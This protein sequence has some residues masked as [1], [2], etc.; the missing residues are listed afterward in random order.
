[1]RVIFNTDQYYLHGGIEKVMATKANYL[2][3]LPNF[4]VYILTTEQKGNS[5]C[6]PLDERIQ[7]IDLS[8]NYDRK[9]SYF[10]VANLSKI[11][12]HFL[13]QRKILKAIAP[14]III[15]PNYNFDH[16]WL[17]FLKSKKTSLI[18]EIHASGYLNPNQR[19]TANFINKL[20][21]QLNDYIL[22]KFSAVVV[23]NEDEK[24]YQ[25]NHNTIVIPNP[26]LKQKEKAVLTNKKVMTAGR[27]A[28]VKGFNHLVEAW[29]LVNLKHPEWVLHIYGDEYAD[30]KQR[31]EQ[32]ITAHK[33][34]EVIVFKD[35]VSNLSEVML[36][37]SVYAMSSVTECFPMVL[38]EAMSVG[39]P[40]VSYDCPNGPRH[41]VSHN[42]D[43]LLVENQN[44]NALANGIL[45]LIDNENMREKMGS[46]AK[47]NSAK[48]ATVFVMKKW[49]NLFH[50]L[51]KNQQ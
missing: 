17:P 15:S 21:W 3:G 4:K 25:L 45:N 33:L 31:L 1:L 51:N 42:S 26:T 8:I 30:T 48:F 19:K 39:L 41:I 38:L 49:T 50:E 28:P 24:K 22:G 23:L 34:E 20:K 29:C 12:K 6:Y 40:V 47:I 2:A 10:S 43:G 9:R 35:T 32:Q 16:Y 36:D 7:K 5:A 46:N 18:K 11:F 14:D 27:I 37:Y 44:P 13:A